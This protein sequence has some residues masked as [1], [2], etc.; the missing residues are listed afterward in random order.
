MCAI[1]RS[2]INPKSATYQ[3]NL[4]QMTTMVERLRETLQKSLYQGEEKHIA[5][6]RKQDKLLARE[7]IEL[8]L[9]P[10]SPFLELMPLAGLN[11]GGFGAG[12][13][14]VCGIGLVD[15]E[16]PDAVGDWLGQR[17]PG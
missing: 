4:V 17:N 11:Q 3:D 7:R 6:A 15:T 8:L 12:G 10:D 13:T 5:K 2:K 9:D 1:I 16:W 14:I